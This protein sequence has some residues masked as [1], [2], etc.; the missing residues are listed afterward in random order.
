MQAGWRFVQ[1][2][3]FISSSGHVPMRPEAARSNLVGVGFT[4][5][6]ALHLAR[7]MP[8]QLCHAP[9][10]ARS[11][12]RV[13]SSWTASCSAAACRWATARARETSPSARPTATSFSKADVLD[14]DG[15]DI[16]AFEFS[17]PHIVSIAF[18][19]EHGR[20]HL[21]ESTDDLGAGFWQPAGGFVAGTG[22]WLSVFDFEPLAAHRFYR[23]AAP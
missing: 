10:S 2:L 8:S 11:P 18:T 1:S 23:I 15:S 13:P 7:R 4:S 14:G 6:N 9:G 22:G 3:Y 21:L 17:R 16:G 19:T 5:A 12:R 20:S